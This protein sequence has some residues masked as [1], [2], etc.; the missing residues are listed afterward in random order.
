MLLLKKK[1]NYIEGDDG[2][3]GDDDADGKGKVL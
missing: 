1:Q 3:G 2:E